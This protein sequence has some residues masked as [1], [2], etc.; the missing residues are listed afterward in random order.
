MV[1]SYVQYSLLTEK[2]SPISCLNGGTCIPLEESEDL[3]RCVCAGGYTGY[4]CDEG[5]INYFTKS[6]IIVYSV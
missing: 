6:Y 3:F 1:I 4:I 2:C 5:M